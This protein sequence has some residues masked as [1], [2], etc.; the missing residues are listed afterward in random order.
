MTPLPC[1]YYY[2]LLLILSVLRA[3]LLHFIHSFIHFSFLSAC[4]FICFLVNFFVRTGM[5]Q[6]EKHREADPV[7][8]RRANLRLVADE[9]AYYRLQNKRSYFGSICHLEK[10]DI[11]VI[12]RT[13]TSTGF[14]I[15]SPEKA[16]RPT[17]RA[18]RMGEPRTRH[19]G[20]PSAE[21]ASDRIHSNIAVCSL[22][23]GSRGVSRNFGRSALGC[24]DAELCN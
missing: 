21:L 5:D 14:L 7:A 8:V 19:G 11:S 1:Y 13:C 4:L 2:Y 10:I 9:S 6:K 24:L 23:W 3:R 20:R 18:W 16:W 17:A 22:E 15:F 12:F